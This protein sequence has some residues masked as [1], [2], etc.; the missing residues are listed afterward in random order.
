VH[1]GVGD[2]NN[3]IDHVVDGELFASEALLGES[4]PLYPTK[5]DHQHEKCAITL[6]YV[7]VLVYGVI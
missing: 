6:N 5:S 2:R 7:I 1:G 4:V 3:V